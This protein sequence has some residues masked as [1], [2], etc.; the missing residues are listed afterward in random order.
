M[1]ASSQ[2]IPSAKF[3]EN[4]Q[5]VLVIAYAELTYFRP[6]QVEVEICRSDEFGERRE[7]SSE[8]DEI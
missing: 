4:S 1:A 6:K 7:L 5:I 3:S 2:Y 8:V